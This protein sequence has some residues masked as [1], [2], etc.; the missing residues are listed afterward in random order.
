[1]ARRK[2]SKGDA[3]STALSPGGVKDE[4]RNRPWST[5]VAKGE[6]ISGTLISRTEPPGLD[7]LCSVAINTLM[8]VEKL[9]NKVEDITTAGRRV[10]SAL[11]LVEKVVDALYPPQAGSE[12]KAEEEKQLGLQRY[13]EELQDFLINCI[14]LLLII[15]ALVGSGVKSVL[16]KIALRQVWR[17]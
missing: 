7:S 6:E 9:E 3:S 5:M 17:Q 11:Q 15:I 8:M 4:S 10:V 1:M 14:D 13:L 16:S 2:S 12:H